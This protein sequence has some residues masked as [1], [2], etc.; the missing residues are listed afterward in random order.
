MEQAEELGYNHLALDVTGQIKSAALGN[1]TA[2]MDQL[3]QTSVD[4][5]GR[6]L[7][8]AVPPRQQVMGKNVFELSFIYDA[9]GC[10]LE[11]LHKQSELSQPLQSG[12]EPWDGEDFQGVSSL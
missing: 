12:W 4:R 2:W 9:D 1:L 3:N 7:R 5:F 6:G 11:F 10:L 8:I